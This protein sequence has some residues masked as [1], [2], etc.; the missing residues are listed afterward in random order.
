MLA[1][2]GGWESQFWDILGK[3]SC[4]ELHGSPVW[5]SVGKSRF[6]DLFG[7]VSLGTVWELFLGDIDGT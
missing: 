5:D 6:W 4:W 3:S 2:G 7:S 1:L